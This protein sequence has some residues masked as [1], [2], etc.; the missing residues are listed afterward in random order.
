MSDEFCVRRVRPS[1][2]AAVAAVFEAALRD[3]GAYHP[4]A[5]GSPADETLPA[6]YVDAGGDFLGCVAPTG[7]A[8]AADVD[9]PDALA[10]DDGVLVGTGALRPPAASVSEAVAGVDALAG[11]RLAE[12]KRLHVHP[13]FHR[14]GL[15][16]RLLDAVVD[17]ARANGFEALVLET[18]AGQT[19]ALAFY[20]S[21][22]FEEATRTTVTP[23]SVGEPIELVFCWRQL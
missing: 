1:D 14:R 5:A 12:V 3:T 15:G 9:R 19:A 7:A 8:T 11:R 4:E 16:S 6:D 13:A 2:A 18:T 20:A 10:V 17:R 21:R 22:G 23:P